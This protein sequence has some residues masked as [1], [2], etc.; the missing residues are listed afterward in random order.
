MAYGY[1]ARKQVEDVIGVRVGA[2]QMRQF[3]GGVCS[4]ERKVRLDGQR[5]RRRGHLR[6]T[7]CL[8][9]WDERRDGLVSHPHE[10]CT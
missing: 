9:S 4:M 7:E 6:G 3:G 2:T 10:Y 8:G 1:Y 5:E